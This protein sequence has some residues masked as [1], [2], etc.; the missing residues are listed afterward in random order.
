VKGEL[1]FEGNKEAAAGG[2]AGEVA[3]AMDGV[4]RRRGHGVAQSERTA[5]RPNIAQ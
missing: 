4:R 1:C 2:A 3:R 5:P